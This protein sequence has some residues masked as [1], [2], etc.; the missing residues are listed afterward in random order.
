MVGSVGVISGM[1]KAGTS[2]PVCLWY[3][4]H[5]TPVV[6]WPMGPGVH[7]ILCVSE[8]LGPRYSI[9]MHI[10]AAPHRFHKAVALLGLYKE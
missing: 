10:E 2:L 9:L 7:G 3:V 8:N 5:A 6:S 1:L 4:P